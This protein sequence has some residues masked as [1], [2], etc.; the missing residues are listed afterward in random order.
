MFR[1]QLN[2]DDLR[3]FCA[4]LRAFNRV[5]IKEYEGIESEIEFRSERAN[6]RG[7][8]LPVDSVRDY[9]IYIEVHIGAPLEDFQ[10]VRLRVLAGEA[11]ENPV[12]LLRDGEI[13]HCQI[14]LGDLETFYAVLT[15]HTSP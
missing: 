1:R 9:V 13:L 3:Q 2:C 15:N 7:L 8:R 10:N 4:H 6:V 12:R 14:G 11:Y 5:I